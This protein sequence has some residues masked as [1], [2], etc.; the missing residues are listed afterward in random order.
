MRVNRPQARAAR[1]AGPTTYKVNTVR[2]GVVVGVPIGAFAHEQQRTAGA[3]L[4]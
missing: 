1:P 3:Y 4:E 2:E